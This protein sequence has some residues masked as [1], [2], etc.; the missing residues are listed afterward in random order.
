VLFYTVGIFA[1]SIMLGLDTLVAQAYGAGRIEE[2]HRYLFNALYFALVLAP[3]VML[4]VFAGIP[5][6]NHLGIDPAV[7][8]TTIPFIKA[9][10]WSMLPL[11]LYFVFRRYLQSMAI[12]KPVV[13]ALVSANAVNFLGNWALV[14]GHFGFPA[15]GV[16]GSGWSTCI[17][18]VYMVLV[19]VIAAVY[20]NRKRASGLWRVPRTLELRRIRE[21]L[22]LG[23]PAAAQ[24][25]LEISA[26]TAA[27]VLIGRL[28][29]VSLAGHQIAMNVASLT[30][31][32][33]LG[34]SSAAAVRVGHAFGTRDLHA[35]SRAG[36]MALFLGVSFMS[37][38]AV[39][40]FVFPRFIARIY[41]SQ[42]EVIQTGATLLMVAAVFQL[43][44]A[45]QVVV[46]G[47]LRGAGNTHTPMWAHFFGYWL[48]GMPLGALL[49]FKFGWGAVGFWIG[50]CLALILIGCILLVV[51]IRLMK[52]F[53]LG[54]SP[55][56]FNSMVKRQ[57]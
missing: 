3:A 14:Y 19:L 57:G 10:N 42:P 25:L 37:G 5:G 49:C 4:L 21:L 54:S 13:F 8:R 6:L 30:Y 24:L 16:T 11:V 46:T 36:W 35:A 26:F 52:R 40:L 27:T 47:A 2:C 33:P 53:T 41:S 31:M 55:Y 43:F 9:L 15:M 1:S 7:V 18:R 29:S 23:V 45:L 38:S 56:I 51:W 12:V 20:Y 32:V 39:V 34:I 44:D 17:S 48:I 22:R 28:G 50:L